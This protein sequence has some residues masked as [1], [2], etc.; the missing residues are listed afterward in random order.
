MDEIAFFYHALPNSMLN[1]VLKSCKGG[2]L[3]K[4]QVIVAFTPPNAAGG[5]LQLLLVLTGK[6]KK[7]HFFQNIDLSRLRVV[8]KSSSKVTNPIFNEYLLDLNAHKISQ[9]RK[10]ILFLD[11]VPVHIVIDEGASSRLI[12]V[13]VQFFPPNLASVFCNR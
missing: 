1:Q 5:E 7:P 3:A 13:K 2:K 8:Y 11:N 6:S 12:H 4:D 10:I 9:N